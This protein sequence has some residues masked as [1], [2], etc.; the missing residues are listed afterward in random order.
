MRDSFSHFLSF[1]PLI[2]SEKMRT[3]A[4]ATIQARNTV[5]EHANS[6]SATLYEQ[7]LPYIG[8]QIKTKQG[9]WTKKFENNVLNNIVFSDIVNLAQNERVIIYS[10]YTSLICE[11]K[12]WEPESKTYVCNTIYFGRFNDETGELTQVLKPQNYRVDYNS[13]ELQIAIQKVAD[14][15][16]KLRDAESI[17]REFTR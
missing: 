8:K 17:I 4:L 12:V 11:I 2:L 14:L 1:N 6:I 7:F 9:L 5:N 3:I 16:E 15:K 13:S 10:S